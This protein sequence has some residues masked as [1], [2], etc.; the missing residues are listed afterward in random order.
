MEWYV[1]NN[2]LLPWAHFV[3]RSI[4][5]GDWNKVGMTSEEFKKLLGDK[6]DQVSMKNI[7]EDIVRFIPADKL[8]EIW[9]KDYF[10]DL[11]NRIRFS[12]K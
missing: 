3:N 2:I 7:K 4:Q 6:I 1:K 10:K 12:D 9:S 11:A 8:I 5:S